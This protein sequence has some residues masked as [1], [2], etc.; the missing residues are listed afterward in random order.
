MVQALRHQ[1]HVEGN[2]QRSAKE[3]EAGL[4]NDWRAFQKDSGDAD[5]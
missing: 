1:L 4:A 3:D 5:A 2:R